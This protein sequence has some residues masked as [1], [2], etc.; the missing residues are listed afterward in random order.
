VEV[1]LLVLETTPTCLRTLFLALA[2]EEAGVPWTLRVRPHGW[3]EANHGRMGPLI[4]DGDTVL[5]L[6]QVIARLAGSP[7]ERASAER[8][9]ALVRSLARGEPAELSSLEALLA[10]GLS[11]VA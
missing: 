8:V 11:P 10:S 4:H 1:S 5:E 3:F 2:L 6:P 7:D 9:G